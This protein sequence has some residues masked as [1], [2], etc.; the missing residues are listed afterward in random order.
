MLNK[1]TCLL[2]PRRARSG[3]A[4]WRRS[5][6]RFINQTPGCRQGTI[7]APV[8]AWQP[9]PGSGAVS[10]LG[11]FGTK[12]RPRGSARHV[13]SDATDSDAAGIDSGKRNDTCRAERSQ[14]RSRKRAFR[15]QATPVGRAG[16][17]LGR[18]PGNLASDTGNLPQRSRQARCRSRP[19]QDHGP[20]SRRSRGWSQR[21]R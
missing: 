20:R 1:R 18:R 19:A 17:D 2:L 9:L 11:H 4:W 5:E 3:E 14:L 8:A 6:R 7:L 10:A 12:T 15:E 21:P 16:H 13:T